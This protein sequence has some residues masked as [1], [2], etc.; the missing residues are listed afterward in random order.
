MKVGGTGDWGVWVWDAEDPADL[1]AGGWQLVQRAEARELAL[2]AAYDMAGGEA[3][4]VVM[5]DRVGADG[6]PVGVV[7]KQEGV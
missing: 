2:A 6:L 1:L 7:A 4:R 3:E 5:V